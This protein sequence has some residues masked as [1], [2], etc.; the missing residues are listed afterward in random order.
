MFRGLPVTEGTFG[1]S[2]LG[3]S[4][5]LWN[6]GR[7]ESGVM[8]FPF[9][10]P[11]AVP[12]DACI[13]DPQRPCRAC[14]APSPDRCPYVYLLAERHEGRADRDEGVS[15]QVIA[16]KQAAVRCGVRSASRSRASSAAARTC[17]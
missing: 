14:L 2:V 16:P 15:F 5:L 10:A 8:E 17:A 3:L 6:A 4:L 12:A 11:P 13:L 9:A 1:S 7:S